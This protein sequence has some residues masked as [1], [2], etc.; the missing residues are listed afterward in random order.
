MGDIIELKA[1]FAGER[2]EQASRPL[3]DWPRLEQ[4]GLDEGE[5]AGRLAGIGGSDANII[6]SG[7]RDRILA[8]WREKRGEAEGPDLGANLA[9]MLGCW[10]EPFNRLWYEKLTGQRVDRLAVALTCP[11]NPWRRCTLDGYI[12]DSDT[13]WEAKH[14][15]AFAKAEEVLERY[16]PQLQ[17]NMALARV[18]RAILSVIFGNHKYELFEVA[19]DWVYQIELLQAEVDFWDCVQTGREPVPAVPPTPPKPIGVR[20]VCLEGNNAWAAA[21]ADWLANRDAARL[22]ASATNELKQLVEPDVARAFG[23]GI[24]A[25]RSKAGAITIRELGQ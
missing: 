4:L 2:R 1:L 6:L 13:I 16:M 18:E 19:S 14:S 12:V 25:R 8:L 15:N 3:L 22:H 7:D 10:T 23:H 20:E 5:R 11:T 24:E 21:A 9:V 17:H